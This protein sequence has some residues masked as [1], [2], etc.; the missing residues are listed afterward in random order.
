MAD[1]K[2]AQVTQIKNLE[3]NTGKKI[4]EW[5]KI[6][7]KMGDLK[8]S[9]KVKRLKEEHGLGHGNA[10]MLVLIA[11]GIVDARGGRPDDV[12]SNQYSKG[13]E[14]LKPIYD[15]I[16][17]EV[18]KFGKDVEFSP[19]KTY[20]SLRRSKQFGLIQ[21]STKTRVDVGIKLNGVAAKGRLEKAGSWNQMVSHRVRLGSPQDVDTDL[22]GWLRKAYEQA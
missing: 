15:K 2:V 18:K 19:K 22:I 9:E 21:P 13:K 5:V 4:D 16:V 6:V 14:D 12:V 1:L 10:S 17:K 3:K 11:R 8:H 7:E 20:V